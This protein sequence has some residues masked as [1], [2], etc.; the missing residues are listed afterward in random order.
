MTDLTADQQQ[1]IDKIRSFLENPDAVTFLLEGGAG[2]GKTYLL[3]SLLGE[4]PNHRCVAAPTHKAINVLR[5]KLDGFGVE[6]CLGFDDYTY[7][8]TDVITGTTAQLLGIAPVITEDQDTQVKFGKKGNGILSKITPSVNVIDEVSMLGYSDLKALHLHFKKAG[9]KLIVVGD[10]GQLPPVK[11]ERIPFG[12]F[13]H[14]AEL[15]QI[16]RQAEGSKIIELAWAVRD[17]RDWS[18]I[19]GSGVRR[20]EHLSNAFLEAV[21]APGERPE[22][23]REVFIAYTNRRVNE[24]QERAC[25][26]LYGHSR[27][28]FA[29]GELVLS[30]TNYYRS[31][32]LMC[33]NQEELVVDSFDRTAFDEQTGVPVVL[34]SRSDRRKA[35][36]SSGYLS[37]EERANKDHPFNV[38]LRA[39]EELA[40]KLQAEWKGAGGGY[41]KEEL[42]TRRKRAWASFFEWR[43]QTIITFRHPFA[44]TSHK[45]QGSTYRQVFADTAD[46]ARF[47][48]QALYVAVTRPKDELVLARVA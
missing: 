36:F 39:R 7:N 27:L 34:H 20:E 6:W 8:G 41:F 31:K 4:L 25:R 16:V 33:S 14:K 23:E 37:P 13:K 21:T 43:D 45:S 2:V 9:C 19:E 24:V 18:R 28:S 15:R 29:P 47:S 38:E 40:K 44:I 46:L 17:G 1:A 26:K 12:G 11:Q 10:A 22:E 42:N 3:G 35:K 30:E 32:V 48:N 5:K